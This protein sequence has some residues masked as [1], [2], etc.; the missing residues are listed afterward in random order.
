MPS[1]KLAPSSVT[2]R[3]RV[4]IHFICQ[5]RDLCCIG[6]LGVWDP[7][8]D[9]AIRLGKV[10]KFGKPMENLELVQAYPN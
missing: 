3:V 5:L 9:L 10:N 6:A 8:R 4:Y 7:N 2:G 1:K